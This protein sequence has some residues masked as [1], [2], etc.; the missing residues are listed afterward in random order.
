MSH[1]GEEVVLGDRG[2][3]VIPAAVRSALGLRAGSRMQIVI[4][5]DGSMTLRPYE[6]AAR[7]GR[8]M[9][10]AVGPRDV[11]PVDELIAERREAAVRED[12]L[13]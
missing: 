12:E 7:A 5:P 8:G 11:S 10:A 1:K 3:L 2:R 6:A 13:A 4:E 9:F